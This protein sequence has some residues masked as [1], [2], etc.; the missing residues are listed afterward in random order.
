MARTMR[1]IRYH[2]HGAAEV[3]KLEQIPVPEPQ[4][5]EVLVRVRAAGVNPVDWKQRKGSNPNLPATPGIDLS[6]VVDK[7]GADVT[8]FRAGQE[9]WGAGQGAYAEYAIAPAASLV[10][11]PPKM[12]FEQAASIAVGA[13]T[14]W[15]ALFDSACLEKGQVVLVLGAAGGVGLWGVQ[16]AK[17]KGARV[18]GT[19]STRNMDFMKSLGVDQS[20][21]YTN[22]QIESV[23]RDVDVVLDTVGGGAHET[24]W[25][26]LK[27]GG[28]LVTIVG[29]P[30]EKLAQ[31][32]G[33][34]AVRVGRPTNSAEIF[35]TVNELVTSGK[36]RT[37]VQATFKLE[38]ARQAHLRSETTHGRGRIVLQVSAA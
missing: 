29:N 33:V 27:R 26:T 16:F 34:R 2:E 21:D 15:A 36:A 25:P 13:R 9:V 18:I 4:A 14:A 28:V 30:D 22:T 19:A 23:A 38:E 1:A 8:A 17:W 37:E 5:G 3:L 24:A 12:T 6:G 11:K 20:V 7:V 32:H 31:K 10:P 35:S